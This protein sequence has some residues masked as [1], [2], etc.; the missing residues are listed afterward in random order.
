MNYAEKDTWR[1]IG[2]RSNWLFSRR[3]GRDKFCKGI[4]IRS[5][6][7]MTASQP[8]DRNLLCVK[9]IST[10]KQFRWPV[11]QAAQW[12]SQLQRSSPCFGWQIHVALAYSLGRQS[13][14]SSNSSHGEYGFRW[15]FRVWDLKWFIFLQQQVLIDLI[16][17]QSEETRQIK[18]LASSNLSI[19][20]MHS[21]VASIKHR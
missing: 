4:W 20:L 17:L 14:G 9:N 1:K 21:P 16:K 19:D 11:L 5:T 6:Q 7:M 8:P 12:S 15:W 13:P 18:S 3:G 10:Q 2:W